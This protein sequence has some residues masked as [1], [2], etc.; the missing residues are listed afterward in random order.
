MKLPVLSNFNQFPCL[1]PSLKPV[2]VKDDFFDTLSCNT[3]DRNS[4]GGRMR[5]S[6]QLKLDTEV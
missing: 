5:F 2:Y 4:H 6:E 1:F 3:L